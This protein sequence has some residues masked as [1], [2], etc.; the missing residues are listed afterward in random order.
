MCIDITQSITSQRIQGKLEHLY[1][2]E[3]DRS[4]CRSMVTAL[5]F[6]DKFDDLNIRW[7]TLHVAGSKRLQKQYINSFNAKQQ[8]I[9]NKKAKEK[10]NV[11]G[12]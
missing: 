4:C 6:F 8:E 11:K 1:I 12:N 5:L 9:E 10:Q 2:I 7:T 3:C